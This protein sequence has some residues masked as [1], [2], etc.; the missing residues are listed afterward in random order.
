MEKAV[1]RNQSKLEFN[2]IDSRNNV[3]DKNLIYA[4][5]AYS[6]LVNG[7]SV[8]FSKKGP[9]IISKTHHPRGINEQSRIFQTGGTSGKPSSIFHNNNT[10]TS[11][12]RNLQN[13][14]GSEPI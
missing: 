2:W 7:H 8:R 13:K 10:I 3:S 14:I 6:M 4:K 9:Q 12:I 11:A 1:M 5:K